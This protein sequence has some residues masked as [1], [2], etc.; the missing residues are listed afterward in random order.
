M[1]NKWWGIGAVWALVSTLA[2]GQQKE[3]SKVNQ[4][5]EVVISDTKFAQSKEKSGKVISKISQDDLKK[6]SGQTLAQ[7]L[8]S[9]A[10][11]EINGSQSASGKNLGY[12]IRGGRNQQV[13]IVIDGNPVTDP[14]GISFEF[15]L[16][17]IPVDQIES[18]EIM[19][20][21]A[22]T[23]YG[24]GA[25]TAVINI[26]TKS[27]G[28]KVLQGNGYVNMGSNNTAQQSKINAQE[29]NQGFSANGTAGQVSYAAAVNSTESKNMS[30]LAP[31]AGQTYEADRFSRINISGKLG[32]KATSK[33]RLDVFGSQDK[34][35]N[36]YDQAFDNTGTGDTPL[37]STTS[38][39]ERFGFSP[40][41][42]YNKGEFKINSAYTKIA[43]DY[44]EF[45]SWMNQIDR[46]SYVG[47][48]VVVDAFNK[49]T[50]RKDL[51]VIAGV[52]YQF[53]DMNSVT[54][55]G[56]I[57][58]DTTKFNMVDPYVTAVWNS[59]F[60]LNLNVGARMNHHSAYG[61][62][63][64]YNVNPSYTFKNLPVKLISSVST[65]YVTPSLYQLYSQYGN[66]TLQPESN[67]T[68]ELGFE[69]QLLQKKMVFTAV[70]FYREQTDS[71]GFFTNPSTFQSNYINIDGMNKAKGVETSLDYKVTQAVRLTANYTFTQVDEALNRLIPKHKAN[72]GLEVIP[73][74]R[75]FVNVNY[76]YTDGRRDL[77]FD[78]NTF[79]TVPVQ[80]GSYSLLNGL[81]K[82][83]L[84]KNQ[85][86]LF[87]SA[88]NILNEEFTENVGYS[89]R[90]RNF[91]IGLNL[92]L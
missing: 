8:N 34:I 40:T 9:V 33:L 14:S 29:F 11:V 4:L 88:T 26:T 59:K 2:Y 72:V 60:G 91:R 36:A 87:A 41:Y 27:A 57:A 16:R 30:Q 39:Q 51:F 19:K 90:G 70:G 61:N 62:H 52:N 24:T 55:Y 71:F 43:R 68:G 64:V 17:L 67:F 46:S 89:S 85:L 76:Q 92:S 21:A 13:L 6:R 79:A 65:A 42:T 73:S 3:T 45:N 22:S 66:R 38:K 7:V 78:G 75:W 47:R 15:D 58:K 32:W 28:K 53:H 54:P 82:Y 84:L 18:I 20:G 49:Y 37:N 56:S 81:V 80:L 63:F 31:P 35:Q 10:G 50:V 5:D 86:T 77:F 83:E 48:S 69:T 12:Y 23:L 25:A 1:N 74:S 44:D